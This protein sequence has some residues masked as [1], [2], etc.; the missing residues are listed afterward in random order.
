MDIRDFYVRVNDFDFLRKQ[1]VLQK[2][3]NPRFQVASNRSG[4]NPQTT[5]TVSKGTGNAN[6]NAPNLVKKLEYA[7]S[8][9]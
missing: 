5:N 2:K 1:W 8:G 7:F 4:N 9:P 3:Y 6:G